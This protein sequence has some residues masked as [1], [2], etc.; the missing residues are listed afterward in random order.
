MLFQIHIMGII[1]GLFDE[2]AAVG[3][4]IDQHIVGPGLQP[5]FDHS[6]QIFVLYF[7]I[8]ETEVIHIDNEFIISVLYGGYHGR[9]ILEFM[10]VD[11]DHAEALIIIFIDKRLDGGGLA[12]SRI[13]EKKTVI[14]SFALDEGFRVVSQAFFLNLI[15]NQIIQHDAVCIIDGNEFQ[16]FTLFMA[17][18]ESPVQT[19]HTHTVLLIEIREDLKSSVGIGLIQRSEFVADLPHPFAD[20]TIVHLFFLGNGAIVR[21]H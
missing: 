8:L 10:L 4:G 19:E 12:G 7:E 11:L 3:C 21:H 13:S 16:R 9:K 2:M 18:P 17:D 5:S 20:V 6:L 14:C 1:P 15:S